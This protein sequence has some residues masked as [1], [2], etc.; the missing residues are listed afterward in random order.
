MK[1]NERPAF[2]CYW[3]K[4]REFC[5][6]PKS[7]YILAESIEDRSHHSADWE[8]RCRDVMFASITEQN[9][10]SFVARVGGSEEEYLLRSKKSLISFV[11][12]LRSTRVYLDMTGLDHSTWASLLR[13]MLFY[14]LEVTVMYA[15]P[16]DYRPSALPTEGT[17]FDLSERIQG[18]TP[19]PGF[20]SLSEPHLEKVCFV[21]MLGFEGARFAYLLESVQPP[22]EKIVPV[23]GVPGFRIEYPFYTYLG[24]RLPL[25]ESQSWRKVRFATANC[26]FAA[27]YL[28][29][30][31]HTEYPEHTLKLAPIG[32][33]PH[34]LGALLY[35]ISDGKPGPVELVYDHPIRKKGRTEG[36]GRLF[37]YDVWKLIRHFGQLS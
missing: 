13:I 26:P 35:A 12:K 22:G 15:E 7:A 3:E 16:F 19:L 28:L 34:A 20:I 33:K 5:P 37:A 30:D 25:S 11:S 14:G 1:V 29:R 31:I 36:T 8:G 18:I 27:F 6:L 23:V 21:P 32:T 24:N 9:V 2:F 10:S 17:I 4:A